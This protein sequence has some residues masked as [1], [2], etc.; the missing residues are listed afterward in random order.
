M[1]GS[2]LHLSDSAGDTRDL[3]MQPGTGVCLVDEEARMYWVCSLF[4]CSG[5]LSLG[6]LSEHSG[7]ESKSW[8]H[9]WCTES[10]MD[11]A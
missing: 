7:T 3:T 6:S 8:D 9:M 10:G 1:E 4:P 5:G 11:N 2:W